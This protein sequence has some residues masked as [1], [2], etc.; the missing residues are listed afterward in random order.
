M[1]RF[2]LATLV[3]IAGCTEG[4]PP[5]DAGRRP[6]GGMMLEDA[7]PWDAGP[8]PD[9]GPPPVC[10][11]DVNLGSFCLEDSDCTD[12]CYCTGRERCQG[13]VCVAG[14]SPCDDGVA[15]TVETCE[16]TSQTCES[17]E[18]D[19]RCDDLDDCTGVEICDAEVGCIAGIPMACGD[20]DSCTIDSCDTELG[21]QHTLR[22]LDEDGYPDLRCAGGTDCDDDPATG[23]DVHPGVLE[24]CENGVD[25]NCDGAADLFDTATCA[26]TNDTCASARVLPGPGTYDFATNGL[27]DDYVLSCGTTGTHPDAVFRFRT[28]SERDVRIELPT[29]P[30]GTVV[31]LRSLTDCTAGSAPVGCDRDTSTIDEATIDARSVPAGDYAILVS[32]PIAGFFSLTLSLTSPTPPPPQDL[33]DAGTPV[34]TASGSYV[35]PVAALG[36]DY[37]D[38]GCGD[39]SAPARE[40][41]F[42]LRLASPMDVRLSANGWSSTEQQRDMLLAIV[43]DCAQPVSSR[44]QCAEAEATSQ[45][46]LIARDGMEPGDYWV[47][48]EE[49]DLSGVD[50][51]RLEVMLTPAAGPT[52]ADQCASALDATN[53][54]ASTDIAMLRNDGGLGCGGS[55]LMYRDAFFSFSVGAPSDVTITTQAPVFHLFAVRTSC[56]DALTELECRGSNASGTGSI[57]MSALGAGTYYVGVA[58]PTDTGMVSVTTAVTP[59]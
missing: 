17:A 36:D 29:A 54:T 23:E 41:A 39:E 4:M 12:R 7:G 53:Q 25:D 33:C 19:A 14:V 28:T 26:P 42:V 49:D 1:R 16:E 44:V 20:G 57:T 18:D 43:G 40:G 34:I 2:L 47:V 11:P 38:L 50:E 59:L 56:G 10:E 24:I 37:P 3:S 13:G 52:P 46:A 9:A 6:D 27:H 15:C 8:R 32:T 58:V 51:L 30:F 21:C 31:E 55:G 22:D 5:V 45:P 48:L 35:I